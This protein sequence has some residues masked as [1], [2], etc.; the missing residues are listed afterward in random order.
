MNLVQLNE[1]LSNVRKFLA[2]YGEQEQ[3]ILAQI[4]EATL[5][6]DK[7]DLDYAK[8]KGMT[9][10]TPAQVDEVRTKRAVLEQAKVKAEEVTKKEI[11]SIK[12]GI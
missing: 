6:A 5:D 2:I 10:A 12:E 3:T 1:E 8:A 4:A 11:E 9:I 7:I